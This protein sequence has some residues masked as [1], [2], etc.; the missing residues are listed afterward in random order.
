MASDYNTLA[1]QGMPPQ[2]TLS[3][4]RSQQVQ[5]YRAKPWY[6]KLWQIE[7]WPNDGFKTVS[8]QIN[9]L[10]IELTICGSIIGLAALIF[11]QNRLKKEIQRCQ[12]AAMRSK[13][14]ERASEERYAALAKAAPVGIFRGDADGRCTYVN[15]CWRQI[16][17]RSLA[18]AA[19][20]LLVLHPDDRQQVG[21]GWLQTVRETGSTNFEC[22]IQRP[23]GTQRWV[24]AQIVAEQDEEKGVVGYVGTFTD[25][26]DYKQSQKA[27]EQS[28]AH[29]R[30]LVSVLPDL[31]MRISR[32]GIFLE[33]LASPTFRILGEP[34]DWIGHHVSDVL[35]SELAQQRLSVIERVLQTQTIEIYEQ[36]FLIEDTVQ[37]EEVRVVPYGADEVLFLVR[38]VS[39]RKQAELALTQSEAQS[40][41]IL[42]AIPDFMCRI[43][44]DGIYREFISQ[45]RDFALVPPVGLAG[46]SMHEVLPPEIAARQQQSLQRAVETGEMQV[47]EQTVPVGDRV[48]EE[49]VRVIKSGADEALLMIRDISDRKQAEK[50]LQQ[51]LRQEQA[52]GQVVQAIRNSL[53]LATIFATA[54]AETARLHPDLNCSVVQYLPEQNLW[55]VLAKFCQTPDL[56]DNTGTEIP[57][58]GNPLATQLKQLQIVRIEDTRSLK[59]PVNYSFAQTLSGAWLLIPLVIEGE[60]WGSLTL[61]TIRHGF[62]WQDELVDLA[63]AV[64][65]QLEVAIQQ[66]QLYQQVAVE[67]QKLLQ[68]QAA[69]AQAQQIAQIGNWELEVDTQSMAC[70][71]NLF[72]LFGYDPFA[73]EFSLTRMLTHHIHSDDRSRLEQALSQSFVE[74]TAFELDLRFFRTDGSMGYLEIRAEAIQDREGQIVKLFGTALD[75]TDR[76]QV[77]ETLEK[78]ERRFRSLA[79][80]LPGAIAQ[81][82]LRADGSDSMM[83]ISPGCYDLWEITAEEIV[84]DIQILWDMVPDEDEPVMRDSI[85]VSA[86]SLEPWIWEWRMVTPSGRTKWLQAAGRPERQDNGDVVWD[87]VFLDISDRIQIEQQL[88]HDSLHDSLTGL[89]NRTLLMERLNLSLEKVNRHPRYQFAVLFLDLDNFKVINDSLGHLVGDQLLLSIA[90]LL[91]ATVRETDLAARLGGDEF[92]ILLDELDHRSEAE[93]IAERILSLLSHPLQIGSYEVFIGTSIGIALGSDRY[94]SAENLLRDADLA[95]YDAK[96]RGRG[97]YALFNPSMHSQALQRL[98]VENDLRKA[99]RSNE[100]VLYY[101]PVV[102]LE[103]RNIQGFEALIRWQHPDRGLL[104]PIEFIEIAE[105]TGLI[106][107]IGRWVLQTACQQLSQ[108]QTQFFDRNV[109]SS[110]ASSVENRTLQVNV[111][112]SVRQLRNALLLEL[113]ETV[114][115]CAIAPNSLCLEIT[116][117]MLVENIDITV[118]L[119]EK[120]KAAGVRI[121]IDD[122]GTGYSSLSYLHQ[123]PVDSLKID[124]SFVSPVDG[125]DRH[126]TIAESITALSKLL[127]LEVI[128]EG[129]ETE[130]QLEWLRSLGCQLGQGYLFS[131]PV[132]AEQ[133][134]QL[135]AQAGFY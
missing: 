128:A 57:D 31:I 4:S 1:S 111:N 92:V 41:S 60:I 91:S 28:E 131:P 7:S 124:R 89:P 12:Q 123:L 63:K 97:C 62:R 90:R 33:F 5:F 50:A 6:I 21:A 134:T 51:K 88:K 76:K 122:F 93:Q 77:E 56:P 8:R 78:S 38:D 2:L 74:G 71:E 120:I 95:M 125:N 112:L 133:A 130:Q 3:L 105:E 103:T 116:E 32:G 53:D 49:E 22:R 132:S 55:K 42:A 58:I 34:E 108:W 16:T 72:R 26:D 80:N 96:H 84:E 83:Y 19:G 20:W 69:L 87:T 129:I 114:A 37:V 35:S 109:I 66:A 13:A 65:G 24:Y 40:R 17:G 48:Q 101:Q 10:S 86:R 75:I 118:Q 94:Q 36:D 70:S 81:Y 115:A 100:F 25:I 99:L 29:Q 107:P 102:N 119:L 47:Y 85:A 82:V 11:R 110:T 52:I 106:E 117:S 121:S 23:D 43:G 27:L 113:E 30:A 64:A 104:L 73:Y 79:A 135:L 18:E 14:S 68:S 54:T 126:Q 9:L 67:K 61:T 59:D 39:D 44:I 46:Q 98:Q 127:K 45:P 15:Q